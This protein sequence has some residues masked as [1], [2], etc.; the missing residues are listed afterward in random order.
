VTGIRL[1]CIAWL[2][3][4]FISDFMDAIKDECF[5][6]K[7]FRK[8]E[9]NELPKH[10]DVWFPGGPCVGWRPRILESG[11]DCFDPVGI[12]DGAIYRTPQDSEVLFWSDSFVPNV[13]DEP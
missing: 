3:S 12:Q 2:G 6:R 8:L 13:K 4:F 10:G 11:V 5:Y 1:R 7:N 9:V